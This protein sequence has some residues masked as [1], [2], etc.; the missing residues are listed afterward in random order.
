MPFKRKYPIRRGRR[1]MKRKAKT[2]LPKSLTY[3][4]KRQFERVVDLTAPDNAAN[5]YGTSDNAVV[6]TFGVSLD[7][8][9]SHS[10]FQNLFKLYKLNY[11]IVD[12]YPSHKTTNLAYAPATSSYPITNSQLL[13]NMWRAKA[14][15]GLDSTFNNQNLLQVSN[16]KT[17]MTNGNKPIRFKMYLNQL[18]ERWD[19]DATIDTL[20]VTKPKY[21]STTRD[22]AVHYGNN[23]HIQRVDGE[24]FTQQDVQFRV[25]YTVYFSCKQVQ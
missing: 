2:T 4:F 6:K 20:A 9:A 14:G 7:T 18:S 22:T 16:K 8:L 17:F 5:W 19:A 23:I 25:V 10:E 3:P 15:I 12:M 11:L 24:P 21:I 1:P 13:V